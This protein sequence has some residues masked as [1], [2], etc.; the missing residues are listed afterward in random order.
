MAK[1]KTKSKVLVNVYEP[2]IVLVKHKMDAACL[3]RDAY[4]DKALRRE[5][6]DLSKEITIP[7][8]DKAKSYIADNLKQLKLKPLNLLLSTET[9]DLI[10]AVCKEKNVTRDAFINR[11]FLLLIAS[12][13]V[14]DQ[15]FYRAIL[16]YYYSSDLSDEE[17][18]TRW[19]SIRDHR[20]SEFW[21]CMAKSL[22]ALDVIEGL[23]NINTSTFLKDVFSEGLKQRLVE[24]NIQYKYKVEEKNFYIHS[25]VFEKYALQRLPNDYVFLKTKNAL[26][27]NTFMTDDDVSWYEA[28]DKGSNKKVELDKLL[29]FT[30]KEKQERAAKTKPAQGSDED[31]TYL[32]SK[33]KINQSWIRPSSTSADSKCMVEVRLMPDGTVIDTKVISSSGDED[34]DRSFE[35]AVKKA[36]PLPVPKDK[37]LFARRF[38]SFQLQF[39]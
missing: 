6:E 36:S 13:T 19:E 30:Q 10:N 4:L 5:I 3:K 14:I 8:S 17:N 38:E 11:F 39:P 7:N 2:L 1:E 26:G 27:F 24:S 28:T 35:N 18:H 33:Q 32:A 12:E 20:I 16:S 21:E 23:I 22:N 25:Y 29:A 31:Q 15:L 37:E 9:V 34:F